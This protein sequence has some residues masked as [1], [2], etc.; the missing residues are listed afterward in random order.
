MQLVLVE[1]EEETMGTVE[2]VEEAVVRDHTQ[3]SI[4][5]FLQYNSS[6]ISPSLCREVRI[7]LDCK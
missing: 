6:N 3:Q 5:I 1:E 7:C 2:G 4:Y